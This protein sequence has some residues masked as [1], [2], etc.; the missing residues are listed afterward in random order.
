MRNY[1]RDAFDRLCGACQ[2]MGASPRM[3]EGKCCEC[4]RTHE[5]INAAHGVVQLT[6]T[7][8][9]VIFARRA[10]DAKESTA[11]ELCELIIQGAEK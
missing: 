2:I 1:V 8:K 5:Q 3:C 11:G 4:E 7:M 9:C 10:V 6:D